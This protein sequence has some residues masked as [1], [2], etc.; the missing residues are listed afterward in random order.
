MRATTHPAH[1]VLDGAG[2]TVGIED[3]ARCFGIGRA[4]AYNLAQRGE[5][6]VRVLKLG[7]RL[8]VPTAD[9]RRVLGLDDDHPGGGAAA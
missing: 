9:L 4:T 3:V 8:R 5:L 1:R 7:T 6:G 2:T